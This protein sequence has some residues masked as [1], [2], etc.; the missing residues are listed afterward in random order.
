VNFFQNGRVFHSSYIFRQLIFLVIDFVCV[1]VCV[2]PEG[3]KPWV[4]AINGAALGGGLEFAMVREKFL[5][6]I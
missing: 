5:I 3:S 1:C 6:E 2:L 4:A